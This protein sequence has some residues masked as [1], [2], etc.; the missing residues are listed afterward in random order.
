MSYYLHRIS[1]E[2][3]WSHP[4]LE[5]GNVLS[6][7]YSDWSS[8]DFMTRH[9]T[10]AWEDV[11]T[12]VQDDCERILGRRPKSPYSLQRFLQMEQGD[13]VIVPDWGTFHVYEIVSD[14]FIP[15]D[16]K[17]KNL[18]SD[19]LTSL[20]GTEAEIRDEKL[21]NCETTEVIDLGFFREVTPIQ[22]DISRA[23]YADAKL[24]RRLKTRQTTLDVSELKMSIEQAIERAKNNQPINFRSSVMKSCA[25]KLVEIIWNEID[26]VQFEQLIR[27]YFCDIGGSAEILP[28]N[29]REKMG[30]ADIIASFETLKVIIY[31]QAKHHDPNSRTDD[32]AVEQVVNYAKSK[33]NKIEGYTSIC[34]VLSLAKDFS[35]TCREKAQIEDVRL[36]NGLEFAEMLLDSGIEPYSY[37]PSH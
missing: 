26:D 21:W 20:S 24:T 8:N 15:G 14:N 10:S 1:H 34:W 13:K 23:D 18:N 11:A 16:L 33:E 31:V 27:D 5:K 7:G 9:K 29:E 4:L 19:A 36:V 28:K 3:E 17:T 12:N 2:Q 6:I 25:D 22:R 37:F 30:D 35:E 32:W